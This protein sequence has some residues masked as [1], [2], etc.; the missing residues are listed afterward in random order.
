MIESTCP[1]TPSVQGQQRHRHLLLL[2]W[3]SQGG[4]CEYCRRQADTEC[5]ATDNSAP[6]VETD[7]TEN[8]PQSNWIRS[9]LSVF[10]RHQNSATHR[11]HTP[12]SNASESNP[13][14]GGIF[15]RKFRFWYLQLG[16]PSDILLLSHPSH[17]SLTKVMCIQDGFFYCLI[18]ASPGRAGA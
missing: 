10:T 14:V 17:R 5:R 12:Y 7:M 16:K 9:H 4:R 1:T 2:V 6:L 11:R 8:Q 3:S 15:S 18:S 13:P